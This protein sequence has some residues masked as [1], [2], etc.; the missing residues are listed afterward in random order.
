MMLLTLGLMTGC[1][2]TAQSP[3]VADT[4]RKE[5]KQ[6][7][8]NDVSVSQ[9]RDKGVV[10]LGGHVN[11]DAD[12]QKAAQIAQT[13]AGSQ[14]VANEVAVLP[15]NDAG[16]TKTVYS[17]LDKGIENNLDAALVSAGFKSGIR[18]DV[19]N[20]VITLKGTV[21]NADQ[22]AQVAKIAQGVP[23]T[24][25]VVNEIQT[26]HEKATTGY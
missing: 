3:A 2:R 21:D 24:Q 9:D 26:K 5:L 15:T 7:G 25:Q 1:S 16:P 19:K 18:H 23:N 6:A 13:V 10:T 12:K 14:V 4:V 22:R 11:S 20:G 8:L 17:D